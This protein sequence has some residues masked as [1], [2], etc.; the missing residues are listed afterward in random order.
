M[1][2]K[3]IFQEDSIHL[4]EIVTCF[5]YGKGG[6][7]TK[8]WHSLLTYF[9][10]RRVS[11]LVLCPVSGLP[12][13]GSFTEKTFRLIEACCNIYTVSIINLQELGL[14]WIRAK[15]VCKYVWTLGTH[16]SSQFAK[17]RSPSLG[18]ILSS[19]NLSRKQPVP[20]IHP[21]VFELGAIYY[22]SS[23]EIMK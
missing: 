22:C 21:S 10:N 23:Q 12:D 3:A 11:V 15:I 14:I 6:L 13:L 4:Q 7:P 19:F 17:P 5:E 1:V 20:P 9:A 2:L 18:V 16:S 8:D